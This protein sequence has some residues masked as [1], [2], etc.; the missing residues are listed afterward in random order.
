MKSSGRALVGQWPSPDPGSGE[1]QSRSRE[2]SFDH[3]V[4]L[5]GQF[6]YWSSDNNRTGLAFAQQ[7]ERLFQQ[8]G[9]QAPPFPPGSR[10][11]WFDRPQDY[12][13]NMSP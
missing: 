6:Q 9:G 4:S 7:A 3:K 2:S 1:Q 10:L 8:I 13:I 12:R 5:V 11:A